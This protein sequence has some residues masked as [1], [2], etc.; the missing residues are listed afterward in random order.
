MSLDVIHNQLINHYRK[1][2]LSKQL[3]GIKKESIIKQTYQKKN[4]D[5]EKGGKV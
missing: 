3:K 2:S 1:T 5:N 4:I